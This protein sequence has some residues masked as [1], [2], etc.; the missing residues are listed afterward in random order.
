MIQP[1]EAFK[2]KLTRLT[3]IKTLSSIYLIKIEGAFVTGVK[4]CP[5]AYEKP[6]F[7]AQH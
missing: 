7:Y 5:G 3:L 2:Y 6:T 1:T 4:N